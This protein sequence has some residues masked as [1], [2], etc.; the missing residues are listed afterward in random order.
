[1]CRKKGITGNEDT[2]NRK[3]VGTED[4]DRSL[5]FFYS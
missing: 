5:N 1:M 2:F 3:T 4:I